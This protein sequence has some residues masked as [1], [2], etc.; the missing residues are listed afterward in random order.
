M[1]RS[2]V[3]GFPQMPHVEHDI[4]LVWP[5]SVDQTGKRVPQQESSNVFF[6]PCESVWE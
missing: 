4:K 5:A 2:P 3:N 6:V 1:S